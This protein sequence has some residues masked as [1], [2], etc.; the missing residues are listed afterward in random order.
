MTMPTDGA[1]APAFSAKDETGKTRKLAELK[2]KPVVLYFYPKDDTPGCTKEAC[3]FCDADAQLQKLGAVVLGV[4]RDSAASHQ[5]FKQ[6]FTLGFPLLVDDGGPC[7]AER[8]RV[9]LRA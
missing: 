9:S 5:K 7:A 3:G 2:R 8:P 6:K 1:K 4:S